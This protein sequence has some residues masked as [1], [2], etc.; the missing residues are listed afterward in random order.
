[1]RDLRRIIIV[2]ISKVQ[3]AQVMRMR[4][5]ERKCVVWSAWSLAIQ[6]SSYRIPPFVLMVP[7]FRK[8]FI[9]TGFA[10]RTRDRNFLAPYV[11][12]THVVTGVIIESQSCP[13]KASNELRIEVKNARVWFPL[14]ADKEPIAGKLPP[15]GVWEFV[16]VL[17][18]VYSTAVAA[19]K[20]NCFAV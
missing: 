10:A 18:W 8:D 2:D 4:A 7:L 6:C 13:G 3:G 16:K 1:M 9:A 11:V 12:G 17:V 14:A 5:V 15:G 20:E 19:R